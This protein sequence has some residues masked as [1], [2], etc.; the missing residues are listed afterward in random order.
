MMHAEVVRVAGLKLSETSLDIQWSDSS[1]M[2]VLWLWL[3]DH[4][5]DAASMHPVTQQ[6]ELFT[7]AIPSG[8]L[9]NRAYVERD[10]LVI[11][12]NDNSAPSRLPLVF[13]ARFRSA[14]IPG[15]VGG[16]SVEIWNRNAISGR[17]PTISF[18]RVMPG[19]TGRAEWIELI[20]RFGFA[21]VSG[22]PA[23]LDDSEALLRRL[24]YV[25]ET[26]FGGMWEFTADLAKADT[27]YTNGRLR[28]H[29]DG[30]YSHDAP[31]AQMLHCL[32]FNGTGGA[33]TLVDG[34]AVAQRLRDIAP[35]HYQTLS[36]VEVPGQYIGDGSHLMAARPAF[37]HDAHGTLQQV[38]FNNYDR[39][40]F[41]LPED[42]MRAYYEAHRAFD[43][44]VNDSEFQWR[45]Q[46]VPGE[47]LVFSNW[48]MLH[49][50]DAYTGVRRMCG[51]YVNREDLESL[52]RVS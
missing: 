30:S 40:P 20:A 46:L 50:R 33:S 14:T 41:L 12:W 25:R 39:A 52:T 27:A 17:T 11:E 51:G 34:F 3:R 43:L 10:D 36:S 8:L 21:I 4:A 37:R 23:T 6:R 1:S 28:P 47:A 44:L 45:H 22:T 31:G 7:A 38:T 49:G 5:H 26:I 9:G 13:L 2:R 35:Q 18:E 24:G 19:G 48:R 15:L 16:A 29:T 42:E 32:E